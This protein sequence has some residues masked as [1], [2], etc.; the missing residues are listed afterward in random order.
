[1]R[2]LESAALVVAQVVK[3]LTLARPVD[4][5]RAE[6]IAQAEAF[7]CLVSLEF[8]SVQG[9]HWHPLP[10]FGGPANSHGDLA[11]V[12]SQL[13]ELTHRFPRARRLVRRAGAVNTLC[14]LLR[15]EKKRCAAVT[16]LGKTAEHCLQQVRVV[17]LFCSAIAA[18]VSSVR[19]WPML[20]WDQHVFKGEV[21]GAPF[22]VS[23]VQNSCSAGV[24]VVRAVYG[25]SARV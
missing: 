22:K 13:L 2:V 25:E 21:A 20:W 18:V 4:A 5:N 11:L 3:H 6:I 14:T 23:S 12:P 24:R 1:V 19:L 10:P 7:A 16:M 15:D 17:L 8:V 9:A